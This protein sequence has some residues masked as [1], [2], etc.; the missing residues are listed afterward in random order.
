MTSNDFQT[1]NT[2]NNERTLE[3]AKILV[4]AAKETHAVLTKSEVKSKKARDGIATHNKDIMWCILQEYIGQ[5]SDFINHASSF[6]GVG[7][8][9]VDHDFYDRITATDVEN[10]LRII[11]GFVYAKEAIDSSSKETYK[12]CVKKLIK[13][14]KLFSED[15]LKHLFI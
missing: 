14:S 7:L 8:G 2:Q 9:K 3:I 5:Y 15:E 12:Q 11:I 10:Q 6:T 1:L 4:K 13:K